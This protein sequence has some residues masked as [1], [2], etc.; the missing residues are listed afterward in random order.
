MWDQ[1][2]IE[3]HITRCN[4]LVTETEFIEFCFRPPY[5]FRCVVHV[6][7]SDW[8]WRRILSSRTVKDTGKWKMN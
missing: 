4:I 2:W 8:H 1:F 5:L 3:K 6:C 7:I